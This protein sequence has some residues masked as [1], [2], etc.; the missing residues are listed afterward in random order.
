METR[1]P[2]EGLFCREFS[3]MC[4][5][6]GVMTAWIRKTWKFCEQFLR[7]FGKTIPLKLSLLR[8]KAARA[9][10][11]IWLTLI[12]ILSKSVHFQLSYCRTREDRFC[13]VEYRICNI[14]S[15]RFS[16]LLRHPAWKRS[17]TILVEWERMEKQENRWSE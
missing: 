9:I 6:C 17:E 16:R 8:Q 10:P 7:F 2:V 1:H 14:G 4:N 15:S 3:A 13:P 5:H 12:Q 11:H